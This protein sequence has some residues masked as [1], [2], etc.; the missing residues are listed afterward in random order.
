MVKV[1]TETSGSS[2]FRLFELVCSGSSVA[3]DLLTVYLLLIG[4]IEFEIN[5]EPVFVANLIR[6]LI[7]K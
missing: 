7:W 1:I 5:L 2:Q 4:L 6:A 3:A